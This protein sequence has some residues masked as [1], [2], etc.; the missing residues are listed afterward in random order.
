MGNISWRTLRV[1]ALLDHKYAFFSM[2][3]LFFNY[4]KNNLRRSKAPRIKI[5]RI[6]I[7]ISFEIKY[8][9]FTWKFGHILFQNE[10]LFFEK[11]KFAKNINSN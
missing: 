10:F 2:S 9:I 4:L 6:N 1:F 5:C 7:C 3:E 8:A 11:K